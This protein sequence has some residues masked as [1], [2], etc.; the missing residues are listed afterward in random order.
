[1]TGG[2]R[3]TYTTEE[4]RE[5]RQQI[6]STLNK[7]RKV[8]M[9]LEGKPEPSRH[10]SQITLAKRRIAAFTLANE[11]IGRELAQADTPETTAQEWTF[12]APLIR[13]EGMD[14]AYVE[15]PYDIRAMFG[16][17]RLPVHAA[18]DGV[19]YDGQ[20]VKMGTPCW[21]IGVN[22]AIRK[23]IGKTFGDE[24]EVTFRERTK[25]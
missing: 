1:M 21:I 19:P 20:I 8:V 18:F 2:E 16:K 7:L 6:D 25:P 3:M 15:V 4:L 17:G 9:T 13:N 14:A 11:L 24:V 22:K 5:A 23:Q 10:R 12:R